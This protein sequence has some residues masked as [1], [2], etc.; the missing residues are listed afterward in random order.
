MPVVLK[1]LGLPYGNWEFLDSTSNLFHYLWGFLAAAI[2]MLL[3]V[4]LGRIDRHGSSIEE[5][6]VVGLMLGIASYG[7]PTVVF[8]T[9]PL[10]IYLLA[11]NLFSFRSF[12]STLIG[13]AFVAVWAAL[14][15]YLGWITNS[16][17]DFFSSERVLGWIP[18]GAA[19]VAWLLSMFARSIFRVR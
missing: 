10:W 7:L 8:M 18:L 15:V 16:W 6:F 1:I 13:F 17:A 9:V 12:M 19:L 4:M 5:C 11:R 3:F 2:V 14:A